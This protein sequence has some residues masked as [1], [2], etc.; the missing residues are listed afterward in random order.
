M[1]NCG[2]NVNSTVKFIYN[3]PVPRLMI[4]E[5]DPAIVK[6]VEKTLT[7][8]PGFSLDWVSDPDKA[9][10]EA[11]DAKPELIQLDVHLPGGDCR[12]ILQSLK[13][14]AATRAVPVILQTGLAN[15]NN[16][17]LGLN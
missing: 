10:A 13:E 17:N 5:D 6:A 11:A 4:V 7:M 8:S 3:G 2:R 1:S 16:K 12:V 14:S 9:V 15:K